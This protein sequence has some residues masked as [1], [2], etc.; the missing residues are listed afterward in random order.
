MAQRL[1]KGDEGASTPAPNP[2]AREGHWPGR[3]FQLSEFG[4]PHGSRT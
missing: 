2:I 4:Q 3:T 1:T